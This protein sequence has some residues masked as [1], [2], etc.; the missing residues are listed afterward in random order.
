VARVLL[1]EAYVL[2]EDSV[3]GK[4]R[5]DFLH[6]FLSYWGRVLTTG[7]RPFLSL[8]DA[9]GPSRLVRVWAGAE[10]YVLGEDDASLTL[11]L[12]NMYGSRGKYSTQPAAL[13]WLDRPLYPEEY[14]KK[15][16]DVLA[17]ARG[18]SPDG[19][20][21]LDSLT[22]ESA[23]RFVIALGAPGEHGPALAGLAVSSPTKMT[24]AGNFVSPL[25]DG[26]RGSAVPGGL[27]A[28]RLWQSSAP[29]SRSAVE[30]ADPTWI[31]GRGQDARQPALSSSSVVII[32]CGSVGAEVAVLLVKAGVG[33]ILLIDPEVLTWANVGRHRLGAKYVGKSKALG[34][35]EE[36][37]EN[38]PHVKA[39]A[40][41]DRWENVARAEARLLGSFD[42]VISATGDWGTE[43]ALNE[44]QAGAGRTQPVLYGWTEPHAC[45]GHALLVAAGGGCLE[46]GFGPSGVPRLSVTRWPNS[47]LK[48]EPACGAA[49]QPYGPVEL[50]HTVN[51]V[52][53]MALDALLGVAVE[54]THRVWATR[55]EFLASC[56]GAW[57]EGWLAAAGARTEGDCR[58][59]LPWPT[60]PD[61]GL[62][63][64]T[65]VVAA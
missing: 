64:G 58:I 32:G 45:A 38:Y 37:R 24:A 8:L 41:F 4:T 2:V 27:M 49:F 48:Q 18:L 1:R 52:A 7:A 50:A 30:R 3:T 39:E 21:L 62:C 26:F 5:E 15:A 46:C 19:G 61:C 57:T 9:R 40:K 12:R 36:L 28:A 20:L 16:A 22:A 43:S 35:A 53:E 60:S 23:G 63:G 10:G 33:R 42:L 51:L 29:V 13:L 59:G 25:K 55:A 17:L 11:W 54:T 47:E 6:E 65:K 31:H 56:G 44:W 34:M 14:P